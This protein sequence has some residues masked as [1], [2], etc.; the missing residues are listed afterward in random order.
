MFFF[1]II[2]HTTLSHLFVGRLIGG[3]R[4]RFLVG[5]CV[6]SNSNNGVCNKYVCVYGCMY[7]NV[8]KALPLSRIL[9]EK[10]DAPAQ[11]SSGRTAWNILSLC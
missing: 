10:N 7:V 8:P 9:M 2:G 4:R 1:K 6:T 5:R 11:S 3:L